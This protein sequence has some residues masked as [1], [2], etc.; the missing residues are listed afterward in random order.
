MDVDIV[1]E[2]LASGQVK[3]LRA[4]KDLALNT[5]EKPLY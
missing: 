3:R 5:A 2:N 1:F 4:K